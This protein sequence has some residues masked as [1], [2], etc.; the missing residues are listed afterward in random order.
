MAAICLT[1]SEPL[2][3]KT[4]VRSMQAIGLSHHC[5]AY[6]YL[7]ATKDA[8]SH[9]RRFLLM[10]ENGPRDREHPA[11]RTVGGVTPETS[12]SVAPNPEQDAF[13]LSKLQI[14]LS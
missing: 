2:R 9:C 3:L 11:T 13:P 10:Y 14:G 6:T 12:N 1:V 5:D 4:V 7:S 8:V